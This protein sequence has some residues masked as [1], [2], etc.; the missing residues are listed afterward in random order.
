MW[1]FGLF[2]NIFSYPLFG[3]RLVSVLFGVFTFIGI[4]QIT[5]KI[6]SRKSALLAIIIYSLSSLFLFFDRQALMESAVTAVGVW[7]LFCLLNFL[8]NSNY[9]N[10]FWLGIIWAFGLW[11]KSSFLIFVITSVLIILI[12]KRK[13]L[14]KI[15][16]NILISFTTVLF[17]LLPF[18]LQK[19]FGLFLQA[20]GKYSLTLAE[21]INL[22]FH[23]WWNNFVSFIDVTFWQSLL[24]LFIPLILF[25]VKHFN[26]QKILL[27]FFHTSI[28]LYIFLT[29]AGSSRYLVAFLPAGVIISS[30]AVVS[31][32][33]LYKWLFLAPVF[34]Y[35]LFFDFLLLFNPVSYFNYLAKV[36]VF[37]QKENYLGTFTSGYGITDAINHITS[38]V[39]GNLAVVGVRPDA[40]NPEDS[41]FVYL[42][43][44]PNIKTTYLSAALLGNYPG[45]YIVSPYPV[46][47]V[48]RNGQLAGLDN[49]LI[50][51]AEFIKP[52]GIDSIVVY[53][54]RTKNP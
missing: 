1:F 32:K 23:I 16:K 36:S 44:Y 15:I 13:S 51:E 31:L 7:S 43:K 20:S 9:K 40:G 25:S 2:A 21:L 39:N 33:S 49:L 45:N 24:I 11:I 10:S 12:E 52:N 14:S 26:K 6:S 5:R 46:Y 54:L 37:S 28:I 19:D 34:T 22:P 27:L 35:F 17:V 48:A 4:Y 29:R 50:K 38:E 47:F 41:T 42:S 30:I 3:A 53:K 18:I 8:E